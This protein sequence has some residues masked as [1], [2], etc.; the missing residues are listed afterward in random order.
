[1]KGVGK[2]VHAFDLLEGD[3]GWF[4]VSCI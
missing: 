4:P 2:F 1:V 3:S